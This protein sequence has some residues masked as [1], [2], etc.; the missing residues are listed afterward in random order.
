[1]SA[2]TMRLNLDAAELDDEPEALTPL[3]HMLNLACG[4]HAGDVTLATRALRR[5]RR[6]R[7]PVGAHPSYPDR[8]GFGRRAMDLSAP[9][10]QETLRAQLAWLRD[11]AH[12]EGLTLTHV[13]PHGALYH[14]ATARPEVARCVIDA[15]RE[16]L[17]DVALVGLPQGALR[18]LAT[19]EGVPFLRE[20]FADRGYTP[21]GGLIPRGSPGDVLTD[22]DAVRAQVRRLARTGEVDTV[23]VHGDGAHALPV[24]R[25]VREA[26]A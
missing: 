23:C 26:L 17:G 2:S 13:K 12:A 7:V 8:E 25:A 22:L 20:G 1:M 5:A 15:A 21:E 18:D 3:A 19:R 16:A 24:A 10:L 11:L 14:A 9:A 4:A 6:H